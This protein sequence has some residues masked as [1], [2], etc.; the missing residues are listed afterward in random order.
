MNIFPVVHYH[1]LNCNQKRAFRVAF[2]L[3]IPFMSTLSTPGMHDQAHQAHQTE[4]LY[5]VLNLAQKS[6]KGLKDIAASI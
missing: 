2:L 3:W 6:P 4:G 5:L 1:R